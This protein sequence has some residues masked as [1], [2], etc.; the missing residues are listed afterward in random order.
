MPEALKLLRLYPTQ[1]ESGLLLFTPHDIGQWYRGELSSRK[2]LVILEELPE[3][4]LFKIARDRTYRI[5]R[6]E[7]ELKTYTPHGVLPDDVELLAE[8]VVDWTKDQHVQARIARELAV[9]NQGS[10]ADFTGLVPPLDE[11]GDGEQVKV[12]DETF[13]AQQAA[14]EAQLRAEG[15]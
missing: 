8:D 15:R 12:A 4:S 5:V 2:L 6:H 10:D 7:G 13:D 1:I 3:T 9:A 11:W 14:I